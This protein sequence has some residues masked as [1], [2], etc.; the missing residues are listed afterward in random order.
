MGQIQGGTIKLPEGV[1]IKYTP[2][3]PGSK[4]VLHEGKTSVEIMKTYDG[5]QHGK[6][7]PIDGTSSV[8]VIHNTHNGQNVIY[9]LVNERIEFKYDVNNPETEIVGYASNHESVPDDAGTQALK[10]QIKEIN[11]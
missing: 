11:I 6:T 10:L 4:P 1:E 8:Q 3:V 7:F 9:V 5:G 2:R